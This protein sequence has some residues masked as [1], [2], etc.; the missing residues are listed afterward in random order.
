[1]IHNVPL[2]AGTDGA[3]F[4]SIYEAK[5]FPR[6]EAH[7]PE[8]ILISAGFDAHRRDPLANLRLEAEDFGWATRR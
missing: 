6:L 8:M 3:M 7:K 4:R 1:M 5:V 2:V